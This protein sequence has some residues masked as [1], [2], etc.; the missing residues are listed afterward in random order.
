MSLR[1]QV[2]SPGRVDEA[3]SLFWQLALCSAPPAAGPALLSM[4]HGFHQARDD[5]NGLQRLDVFGP[6]TLFFLENVGE[7]SGE[8]RRWRIHVLDFK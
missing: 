1:S 6:R 2:D 3:K 5:P 8:S 4:A 7:D